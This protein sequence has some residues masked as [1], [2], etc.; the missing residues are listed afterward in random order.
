MIGVKQEYAGGQTCALLNDR[1]L[2]E[3]QTEKKGRTP[4]TLSPIATIAAH[5][6][7]GIDLPRKHKLF[8]TLF[9]YVM[10]YTY[11]MGKG[12]SP[13]FFNS[14]PI[15]R[16]SDAQRDRG[17]LPVQLK[18]K[19][20]E[21]CHDKLSIHNT[22]YIYQYVYTLGRQSTW[23]YILTMRLPIRRAGDHWS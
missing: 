20:A 21:S 2:N 14:G 3:S 22:Y 1:H 17:S 7:K 15:I 18:M 19:K 4:Q 6:P 23:T 12:R 5:L 11:L 9:F 16:C 10:G 8:L 13:T